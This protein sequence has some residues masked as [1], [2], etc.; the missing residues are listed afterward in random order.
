MI[1]PSQISTGM[2]FAAGEGTRMQPLTFATPKPLI[3][4]HNKALIDYTVELAIEF[5]MRNLVVNSYYLADQIHDYVSRKQQQYP[6][7]AFHLSHEEERLETAGGIIKA[8]PYLNEDAFFSF[9][10]D[11]ILLDAPNHSVLQAMN[12][13]WNPEKMSALLLL[14]PLGKA[15]GYDGKGNFDLAADNRLIPHNRKEVPYVFTGVQILSRALFEGLAI[16][17]F[18]LSD[19]YFHEDFRIHQERLYGMV[20]QGDWLH[21]GTAEGVQLAEDFIAKL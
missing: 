14:H 20:H 4:I 15:V 3:P 11:V 16:R 7:T 1:S 9:N 12:A 13:F 17:K 19:I 6:N 21:I 18:S 5:G 10:S 2:I 8:L